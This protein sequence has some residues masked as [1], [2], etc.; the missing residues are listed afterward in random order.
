MIGFATISINPDGTLIASRR[1]P[2]CQRAAVAKGDAR[3]ANRRRETGGDLRLG[4]AALPAGERGQCHETG[5]SGGAEQGS[6]RIQAA[7]ESATWAIAAVTK[8]GDTNLKSRD[9]RFAISLSAFSESLPLAVANGTHAIAT[10]R[11]DAVLT[12]AVFTPDGRWLVT[13]SRDRTAR[14][15]ALQSPDLIDETCARVTRNL[16]KSEWQRVR[17]MIRIC[18]SARICRCQTSDACAVTL[19]RFPFVRSA[20]ASAPASLSSRTLKRAGDVKTDIALGV[21]PSNA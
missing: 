11:H 17:G 5:Q 2:Y 6:G 12:G 9:G 19:N 16:S 14:V 10:M 3:L 1:D 18:P 15:W 4:E 7:R 20:G 8:P 13:A 21:R